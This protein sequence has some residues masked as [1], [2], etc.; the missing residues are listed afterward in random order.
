MLRKL[1]PIALILAYCMAFGQ[2]DAPYLQVTPSCYLNLAGKMVI[3]ADGQTTSQASQQV[4]LRDSMYSSVYDTVNSTFR[5]IIRTYFDYDSGGV[6]RS[7][8]TMGA[9][10]SGNNWTNTQL[11]K[12]Q[13][14]DN[15]LFEEM[16][17]EWDKTNSAWLPR[18]KNLYSFGTSGELM[19]IFYEPYDDITGLWGYSTKDLFDISNGTVNSIT[20]QKWNKGLESWMSLNRTTYTYAGGYIRTALSEYWDVT[21]Q[22]WVSKEKKTT[23]VVGNT[24]ETITQLT[25]NGTD[26]NNSQKVILTLSGSLV[27]QSETFQWVNNNW[28]TL[29][30]TANT[31]NSN[32]LEEAV[33]SDWKPYL[34]AYRPSLKWHYYINA[35]T[36]YGISERIVSKSFLP[37]PIQAG[38]RFILRELEI[39]KQVAVN[40]LDLNGRLLHQDSYVGGTILSV[41]SN[42]RPGLY[43]IQIIGGNKSIGIQKLVIY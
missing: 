21:N 1:L 19:S 2:Q 24:V 11:V 6:M 35:H 36:V 4:N 33:S 16:F 26:W 41:P 39:G 30:K 12:Y 25:S 43:L 14:A 38:D 13:Y 15:V 32:L 27:T 9:D 40:W 28:S 22:V 10:K 7:L 18:T 31:Y 8:R 37:N 5:N 23:S 3:H 20:N 42:L 29:S 17:N 34:S